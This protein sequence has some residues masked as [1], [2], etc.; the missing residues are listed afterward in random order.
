MSWFESTPN[1]T[2]AAKERYYKF[3][4][5]SLDFSS[6]FVRI[7]SGTGEIQI[8]GN[9]YQG[10]GELCRV[11][12]T[13]E[14]SNLTVARKTYQLAGVPVD[15]AQVSEADIEASFGRSVTEYMGFINP[16]TGALLDAPEINFEG[17][18]SN[19]RRVFGK[20]PIIEVNAE[21]RLI[22]LDAS[23]GWRGTHEH[24]QE[25]YAGD[26]GFN[27]QPT[28]DLRELIWGGRRG[29]DGAVLGGPW[30]SAQRSFYSLIGRAGMGG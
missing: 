12:D 20:E 26:L 5:V 15:P 10:F 7:W 27:L 8:D 29:F 30:S 22:V 25:F 11:S 4:A 2:E 3:L 9:T 18:M 16:D 17:E 23:D 13:E 21:H 14:R 24:Q 6:G 1:A 19:I 28:N